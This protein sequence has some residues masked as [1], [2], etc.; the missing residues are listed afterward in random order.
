M[1][2][3]KPVNRLKLFEALYNI[4][5]LPGTPCTPEEA[6]EVILDQILTV[7]PAI[8]ASINLINPDSRMLELEVLRGMPEHSRQFQLSLG[9]GVTGWVALHGR[10]MV[11]PDVTQEP[12][13]V[14]VSRQVKSEIA[15]PMI[16]RGVVIGVINLNSD[17]ISAYGEYTLEQ[18]MGLSD[19]AARVIGLIWQMDQLQSKARALQTLVSTSRELVGR[20]DMDSLLSQ[21]TSEALGLGHFRLAA[22][23]LYDPSGQ[24]LS[25]EA[26]AGTRNI[27]SYSE[28]LSLEES[29]I[30]TAIRRK[31]Q[32]EVADLPRSEEHH[33][34]EVVQREGLVSMLATPLM[35][36]D[37]V[38]GVLNIYTSE[39]HRFSDDERNLMAALCGISALAI[40]NARLYDRVFHTEDTLRR[41]DKLT[42][43]GLLSA[44]I[45]HEIRNPLT[46][47][48]L[49]FGSLNLDF[50]SE[51]MRCRDVEIIAE[52]LDQ[53]EGI[54]TRVL[55][56]SK[57]NEGLHSNWDLHRIV[58]DTLYLVRLK[59]RQSGIKL[60]YSS[61][62]RPVRVE[63][64]KGQLQ[65]AVLNIVMN[66]VNA[67]PDG[68]ELDV[69]IAIEKIDEMDCGIIRVRDTG[70]GIPDEIRAKIFDSFLTGKANGTGLGLNISKRI[71]KSHGGDIEVE[72]SS[73]K[74]T[75]VKLWLPLLHEA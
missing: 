74:G 34:V 62:V 17:E 66:A 31:K 68:G 25:V 35:S 71:L 75:T 29:A 14:P 23:F 28:T 10:P 15:A 58:D 37:E 9:E 22:L 3:M 40:L 19:E 39:R 42:T 50:P 38:I 48:K 8:S 1:K 72:E 33:F 56:F 59:L 41:N 70:T 57:N 20:L 43:L 18:L 36:E 45:A 63:V 16:R 53:L 27:D 4:S 51:D 64:S 11:V 46:V 6:L 7:L 26:I 21:I 12:H 24:R 73:P 60:D 69:N 54:V 55:S 44:E 32:V 67:M 49:L 65:Q 52:K 13:Y 47:I 5:K 61:P 2:E 30:G